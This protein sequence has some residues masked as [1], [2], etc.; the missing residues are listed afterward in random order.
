MTLPPQGCPQ[1]APPSCGPDPHPRCRPRASCRRA[2]EEGSGCPSFALSCIRGEGRGRMS[3]RRG[4]G[5]VWGGVGVADRRAEV[6]LERSL[7]WPSTVRPPVEMHVGHHHQVLDV[8]PKPRLHLR[9]RARLGAAR[10]IKVRG[11]GEVRE[12]PAPHPGCQAQPRGQSP[13]FLM[14]CSRL[15][16][17]MTAAKAQPSATHACSDA[18][19]PNT[20]RQYC[21]FTGESMKHSSGV[22]NR[23]NT[24]R[25]GS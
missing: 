18:R 11:D 4:A 25:G 12:P 19:G 5:V 20:K 2:W 7:P 1:R 10:A 21:A 8:V 24:W 9:R 22:A 3:E 15:K 16:S 14:A 6:L 23:T 17:D 13:T